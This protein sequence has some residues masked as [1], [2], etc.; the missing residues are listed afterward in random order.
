MADAI[1]EALTDI[2][3]DPVM[4]EAVTV[5]KA[6]STIVEGVRAIRRS[7]ETRFAGD[8]VGAG[9]YA[10]APE[11]DLLAS[12]VG[13]LTEADTVTVD[14]GTNQAA[15]HALVSPHTPDARGHLVRAQL[16]EVVA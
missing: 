4:A 11:I 1:A 10:A 5:T 7:P 15:T 8:G 16:G 2:F 6:D 13:D 14:P 12:E 9:T 3:A